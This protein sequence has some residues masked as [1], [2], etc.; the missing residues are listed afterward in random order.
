M[1]KTLEQKNNKFERLCQFFLSLFLF[2]VPW[3]TVFLIKEQFL[4]GAKWQY[5]TIVFF[6][7]EI[8]LWAL[9]FSF[10][11]WFLSKRK[12]FEKG[13][14]AFEW[15]IDRI[16]VFSLFLFLIYCFSSALWSNDSGVAFVHAFFVLESVLLFLV[17]LIFP[18]SWK[19]SLQWFLFG[20]CIQSLLGIW[21]FFTQSTVAFK[22]LGLV[23]HRVMESGT[24]VIVGDEIGRVLRSYG[25]FSHPNVFGGYLVIAIALT[26]LFLWQ[27]KKQKFWWY[28]LIALEFLAVLLTFSRSSWIAGAV[29][30]SGFF[31]F[32]IFRRKKNIDL[33]LSFIPK[34]TILFF[35]IGV[36]FCFFALPLIQN[37]II[38]SS[39]HEIRSINERISGSK[40]AFEIFQQHPFFGVG[41]GN[42]TAATAE[43]NPGKPGYEYQPVHN[44]ALLL[45]AELGLFGVFLISFIFFRLQKLFVFFESEQKK[46]FSLFF[47]LFLLIFVLLGSFDHYLFSSYI[48][49]LLGMIFFGF[50]FR[51]FTQVFP[52]LSRKSRP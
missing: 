29:L 12:I 17:F 9:F 7:S 48:G 25:A 41:I 1:I 11:I 31:M 8:I 32:W 14:I 37:R 18:F 26:I 46:N 13:V 33:N 21:Q 20:A 44:V 24:S 35:S 6:L 27:E 34:I 10:F 45:L 16:F 19:T 38:G 43:L 4:N 40:E 49:L 2:F 51:F 22:W 36:I 42:Y 50:C 52:S 28:A 3:Q 30:V 39:S 5:G 47:G 23:A 15:T